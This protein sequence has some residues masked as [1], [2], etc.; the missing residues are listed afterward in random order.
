MT[1]VLDDA[2]APAPDEVARVQPDRAQRRAARQHAPLDGVTRAGRLFAVVAA[3]ITLAPI[4]L[5][6][7]V[8]LSRSWR[9]GP[10]AGMTLDWLTGAWE[11]IAPNIGLSLRVA[12]LV[13]V[14]DLAIGFPAAWLI[15]RHRFPGR[16]LLQAVSTVPIAVPGIAIGLGLILAYPTLRPSGLLMIGGHVLYTLPFLLGALVPA[17][18]DR[19]LR[20]QETVA[21]SLGAGR[22]RRLLTVTIPASRMA[23]LAATLM[24]LTLSFGEFNVSFFLFT[25]L[26]QPVP[27]VLYDA[28][29]TGRIE[30]AAAATVLFLVMVV[31][32]V[33][34][35]ERLGGAKVGQ[36]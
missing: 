26:Q 31:P 17:L 27:V 30:A 22:V 4:P 19:N 32:A 23:L 11:R 33:V 28:Y 3:V 2:P 12:L 16:G 10:A 13:L 18:G 35:L 29:L 6:V 24:V 36:A 15:A 5:V 34:A 14:V 9:E 21:A 20:L 25:P 1:A 8:A 7:V